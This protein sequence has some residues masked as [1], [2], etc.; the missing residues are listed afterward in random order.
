[1]KR[2]LQQIVRKKPAAPA[3]CR[4]QGID[5]GSFLPVLVFF[6]ILAGS[7]P[8]FALDP[9]TL[10]TGGQIVSGQGGIAQTGSSMT[11]TQQ[12]DRLIAHW[13]TFNIGRDA[14]VT[15]R[16]PGSSS[17]ALNRILDQTPSQIYGRLFANGQVFL[18]NP[19]GI[20]FSPTAQVNVGGLVASTLN[21]TDE[22][23]LAGNHSFARS[24]T[25][26]RIVNEGKITAADG[27][28]IAF[29]SPAIS[30]TGEIDARNGT[31]AM[32]AGDRVNLDFAG[33]RLINF[34]ILRGTVDALIENGGVIR[35]NGGTVI[36]SAMAAG[37]LTR[38]VVNHSGVIEARTLENRSGRILLLADRDR[39][40][41][42]VD[43]TLD[44]SA[45]DGG[46]GGFIETSAAKVTVRDDARVTTRAEGGAT[47]LW[48]IDPRDFTIA[49]SGGDMTGVAATAALA[50]TSLT[51][52]SSDGAAEGNGDIFVNDPITWSANTFTLSADRNIEINQE[53]YGSGTARLTLEYGQGAKDG[54]INGTAAD[55]FINA[56]VNL[57]EGENLRT[58]L[59]SKGAE[60]VFTVITRLGAEG[61]RT[62]TDLQGM[63][64]DLT[65]NYA[66]GADIDAL[67]TR[68]WNQT[69]ERPVVIYGFEPIGDVSNPYTGTFEGLGHTISNIYIKNRQVSSGGLFGAVGTS[70]EVR[71]VRLSGGTITGSG[72]LGALVGR[73]FGKVINSHSTATVTGTA[74]MNDEYNGTGGLV[75]YNEG[76]ITDCGHGNGEV[77]GIGYVG[78]IV[79]DNRGTI[80]DSSNSGTVSGDMFVGGIAGISR[81]NNGKIINSRNSGTVAANTGD[82]GG[83]A[84]Q[85]DGI[86]TGSKNTGL[87]KGLARIGGLA[88]TNS[89]AI[90]R[91][92]N[93]GEVRNLPDKDLDD[94]G[95]LAGKNDMGGTIEDSWNTGA[96]TGSKRTGG[97]AGLNGGEIENSYNSGTVT[98]TSD[99]GGVAGWNMNTVTGSFNNGSV[100]GTSSVGGLV[101]L[102]SGTVSNTYSTGTVAGN[103][104]VGGLVGTNEAGGTVTNSYST[105]KVSGTS[106]VGGLVGTNSGKVTGSFWDMEASGRT[107]SAA[108]IGKTTAEMKNLATF[109]AAGWDIDDAGQTGKVWRIYDGCTYPLLRNFMTPATVILS[110]AGRTK[111][112]DGTTAIKNG[113]YAWTNVPDDFDE[114]KVYGSAVYTTDGKDVGTYSVTIGGLYSGQQGYDIKGDGTSTITITPRDVTVSYIGKDKVYD[115][116]TAATVTGSSSDIIAG[117]N[118]SFSQKS[119]FIDKNVGTGKGI[120]VTGISLDGTDSGNYRLRHSAAAASADITPAPLT[121]TANDDRK[122]HDGTAYSGG[123]GVT[124]AGFVNGENDSVLGGLLAYGGSSQG[125]V[126]AGTYS[127]D[128]SGLTSSNYDLRFVN[129]ILTVVAATPPDVNPSGTVTP[130][131]TIRP[132]AAVIETARENIGHAANL[133]QR[134]ERIFFASGSF[135]APVTIRTAGPTTTLLTGGVAIHDSMA[136]TATLPVFVQDG[137]AAPAFAGAFQVRENNAALS[138]TRTASAP[139]GTAPGVADVP[140]GMSVSFSLTSANG[141]T[142]QLTATVTPDGVLLVRNGDSSLPAD[143]MEAV[144]TGLQVARQEMLTKPGDLKSV[145]FIP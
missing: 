77:T 33:D 59:G 17:I 133:R 78:G 118:V 123:N 29:L 2:H 108:G 69:M 130:P 31:V 92:V 43:G 70:G 14:S 41:V 9:N 96:V 110:D 100:T 24:G 112:Y 98:G 60:K 26:G 11:V 93:S 15:F 134:E 46:D 62:G 126:Q 19:A 125:A 47:G 37:E 124:Y 75:G 82:G 121:V 79:G 58:R 3:A 64:G 143:T 52:R 84:G 16:Q 113:S 137:R 104:S 25:A 145:V 90:T 101:G 38:A 50:N 127:I 117:D 51:I 136:E 55:Y 13:N 48:L 45:P 12:T 39:G 80:R 65:K 114:S 99:V 128:P 138:L 35:A 106:D 88:G 49:E 61:S 18:V 72:S 8:A 66:L 10:P 54:V 56:R 120:S 116:T 83:I 103:S 135:L 129:G 20:Y 141:L 68:N 132:P 27:G 73:N 44:A 144:L 1:M 32:A 67:A 4:R 97:L 6:M 57:P 22:D 87:V 119:D 28:Y 7:A 23:F 86:I 53:L 111:V 107:V 71:N 142:S 30:N 109:A 139:D 34:T 115:G 63:K 74:A 122:M 81:R 76:T 95:G 85:N 105:G 5:A 91:S 94:A 89:G 21:I 131:G 102:N 36:L 42:V 40:T 140:P